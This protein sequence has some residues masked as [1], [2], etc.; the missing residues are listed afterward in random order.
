MGL[1]EF[2]HNQ[3]N[4]V[5]PDERFSGEMID[6]FPEKSWKNHGILERV[7]IMPC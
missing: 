6:W 2:R 4:L 1:T 7:R 5:T 3:S